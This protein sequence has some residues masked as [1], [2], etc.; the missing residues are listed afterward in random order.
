MLSC[1]TTCT[2]SY[3]RTGAATILPSRSPRSYI[4]LRDKSASMPRNACATSGGANAH[5][6]PRRSMIGVAAKYPKQVVFN[7][8]SYDFN[9]TRFDTLIEKIDYC[10]KNPITRG[11]VDAPD[12][13]KWSS[14]RFYELD[15][16]SVL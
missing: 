9:I 12:Q 6:G 10:H 13:W 15:D 5:C 11:L 7:T 16:R 4:A 14:F 1:Q 8:R 2:S 3:C